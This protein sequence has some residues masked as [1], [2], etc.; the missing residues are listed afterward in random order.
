MLPTLADSV[1]K[2]AFPDRGNRGSTC[3]MI[4]AGPIAF[5]AKD[6]ARLT[7]SSCRQ[8]FSGPWRS[9]WRN[10]VASITSRDHPY[11]RRTPP[12][13]ETVLV[14]QVDRWR[15]SLRL[16]STTCSNLSAVRMASTKAPQ[17]R[18]WRE[19]TATP[20]GGNDS[21][22][23]LAAALGIKWSGH[24]RSPLSLSLANQDSS[25]AAGEERSDRKKHPVA[26]LQ[27]SQHAR[28]ETRRARQRHFGK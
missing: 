26:Q 2:T 13:F 10:P 9:S 12:A 23:S 7:P 1:A 20:A 14:Q 19:T 21:R 24:P 16:N 11:R 6:R 28:A 4:S 3:F 15:R 8:L 17:Y 5:S 18:R 27:D 22:S 25:D